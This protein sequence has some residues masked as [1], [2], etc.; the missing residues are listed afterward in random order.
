MVNM[1]NLTHKD[2]INLGKQLGYLSMPG[3]LCKGFSGMLMQA[4]LAGEEGQFWKRVKLIEKYQSDFSLL[5][6]K[7][8]QVKLKTIAKQEL[9]KEDIE[10]VEI[11]AF[12][13]G[14]E[15]YL[16]PENHQDVFNNRYVPQNKLKDIYAL[17]HPVKLEHDNLTI[18]L[19]NVYAFN[20]TDLMNYINELEIAVSNHPNLPILIGSSR[21]SV[22]LKYNAQNSEKPWM[23]VDTNEF[24]AYPESANYYREL[25][26]QE[27]VDALFNSLSRN[28]KHIV[29]CSTLAT[30]NTHRFDEENALDKLKKQYK[31]SPEQA[32]MYDRSGVGLLFFACQEGHIEAI[33]L[34]L[35]QEGIEVNKATKDGLTP[36]HT[37]CD[38]GHV[39]VIKLLLAHKGIEANKATKN[40]YTPLHIAC[41]QRH[42]EVIKL[43]VQE[44]IK[45]GTLILHQ[46]KKN[47]AFLKAILESLPEN[48]RL[49]AV[50]MT[51]N[52]GKTVLHYAAYYPAS[53]RAILEC[54]PENQRLAAIKLTDNDGKTVLHYAAYNPASFKIILESLPENQ[55]LAAVKLTHDDNGGL[56][57]EAIF[58]KAILESLPENQRLA[59][60][61]LVYSGGNTVLHFAESN[62]T[63]LRVILE[64]LPQNQRLAAVRLTN[65]DGDTV[66]HGIEKYPKSLKVT[67]DLLPEVQHLHIRGASVE[68]LKYAFLTDIRFNNAIQSSGK[69][70]FSKELA[71][72]LLKLQQFHKEKIGKENDKNYG[73][74]YNQSIHR[75]YE[76]ALEIRLSGAP[77]KIQA[78]N[79]VASAHEEFKPRHKEWRLLADA[80]MLISILFGGLGLVIMAGRYSTSDT[81]FFSQA[82][83]KREED[84]TK[85]LVKDENIAEEKD[86]DNIAL[87]FKSL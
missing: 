31:I 45:N 58:F 75:F 54:L 72:D 35:G 36:L 40:G 18:L 66:L 14:M 9:N 6:K 74:E 53:L 86:P 17:T 3:G 43:L 38:N 55:R 78:Q 15:L 8:D 5:I 87:L 11:L 80:L 4:I 21:H 16:L 57:Y 41:Q 20:N 23:Y 33:R 59:V 69:T 60:V 71:Y 82:I 2:L 63:F 62:P 26:T 56:P 64:C 24:E 12:Y 70:Q 47:P 34:L 44:G 52:D 30:H 42:V 39:E 49:A 76:R 37:A 7:I 27:L 61:Q 81:V 68:A 48:Q 46:A 83:T 85:L 65:Y 19:N 50:K 32:I 1:A 79:I 10:L 51:D 29:F 84:L 22:L 28:L 25:N 77:I 13:D 73:K 67:L